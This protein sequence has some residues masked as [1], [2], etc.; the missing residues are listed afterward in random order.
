MAYTDFLASRGYQRATVER[1]STDAQPGH[2]VL[3][4]VDR[5]VR[6]IE[7]AQVDTVV[8]MQRRVRASRAIG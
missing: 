8:V 3:D 1:S 7:R 6:A 2:L 5:P 4:R